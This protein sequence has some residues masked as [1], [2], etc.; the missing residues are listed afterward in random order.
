MFIEP[1]EG[2]EVTI[3]GLNNEPIEPIVKTVI[4]GPVSKGL[5]SHLNTIQVNKLIDL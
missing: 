5:Q 2:A 1:V 4:P 3:E